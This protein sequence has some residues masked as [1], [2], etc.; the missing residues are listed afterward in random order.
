[1]G[2]D[3]KP[4]GKQILGGRTMNDADIDSITRFIDF[5]PIVFLDIESTGVDTENDRIIEIT[6]AVFDSLGAEEP[7]THR[8]NPEIPIPAEATEVHGITDAGVASSPKFAELADELLEDLSGVDYGGF[9]IVGFDLPI[10]E[11]EFK[12]CGIAFDWTQAYIADGY[13][14][15]CQQEP[16]SLEGALMFYCDKPLE[17][18]H[19]SRADVD[20]AIRVIAAQA[21]R[22][23]IEL[24]EDLDKAGRRPEWADRTGRLRLDADG[25]LVFGFGKHQGT[26]I[27]ECIE[28]VEWM[29]RKDFPSDT[30][31][32][33]SKAIA[34][35][36]PGRH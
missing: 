33:L 35:R 1:M 32:M 4:Q 12:R 16:R 19:G 13:A 34:G 27:T 8:I 20:A 5:R 10:L 30:K 36:H 18:A 22:Y 26:P 3:D 11:A 17:G 14:I 9:N 28:Y 7:V 21:E 2:S 29:L 15:M 31:A 6:L 25:V 24:A 23:G